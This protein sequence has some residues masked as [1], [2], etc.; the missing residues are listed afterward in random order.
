MGIDGE[1]EFDIRD[2][3]ENENGEGAIRDKG[4]GVDN[5]EDEEDVVRVDDVTALSDFECIAREEQPK[6]YPNNDKIQDKIHI[7]YFKNNS[8]QLKKIIE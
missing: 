7:Y 3:D 5:R 6:L 1:E 2:K 4:K 8:Q